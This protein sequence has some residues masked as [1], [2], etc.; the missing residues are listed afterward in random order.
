MRDLADKKKMNSTLALIKDIY[1]L[2]KKGRGLGRVKAFEHLKADHLT[3][4]NVMN[5][6][7]MSLLDLG[8]L[9]SIVALAFLSREALKQDIKWSSKLEISYL[10][11]DYKKL[12][13]D[14]HRSYDNF[15]KFNP[16]IRFVFE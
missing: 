6:G 9:Y 7:I 16:T 3:T 8:F 12:M 5:N 2:T 10:Q 1:N 15:G 13:H 4:T 11:T 14:I